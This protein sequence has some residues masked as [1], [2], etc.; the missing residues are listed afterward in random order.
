MRLALW[1]LF[2][3]GI[4][5]VIVSITLY[6]AI[7]TWLENQV[8]NNLSLTATQV[9]SVLYDA[10]EPPDFL[11]LTDVNVQ[12]ANNDSIA[13]QSFLRDQLFFVRL[14]SVSDANIIGTSV[15]YTIPVEQQSLKYEH[16]DTVTT[17]YDEQIHE[18]RLYTMSLSYNPN[19][20]LQVGVSLKDTREIQY[21]I[22]RILLILLLFTATVATLSGWFLANRA[23]VPIRAIASTA[24][25]INETD[26]SQRLDMANS[27]VE[28]EQLVEIFNAM[29]ERIE[30]AFQRQR[31]LTADAAHE[32]RTPLSVMRTSLDVILSQPRSIPEYQTSLLSV[33]EEVERMSQLANT[34]LMLARSDAHELTVEKQAVDLSLMLDTITEQFRTKANDKKIVLVKKIASEL[35]IVGDEDRLIQVVYNLMDNAVKYTSEG[36]EVAI[37]ARAS[38]VPNAVAIEIRDTGCGISQTDLPH[39]FNRFYRVDPARTREQGGFGLGLAI[40]KHIVGLHHGHIEVQSVLGQ[41]TSFT[42]LLPI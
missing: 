16:F 8:N 39:I 41:G 15:D 4:T 5:Q 20:A 27:E 21:D 31:Q 17:H 34:L 28:L 26:L 22:V 37:I 2:L 12:L 40:V 7:S 19:F 10:E 42:L 1:G 24:T 36:G 6:V 23:L 3:F 25:K 38:K 11:D 18:I 29:L 35:D 14:V 9:S 30:Q 13:T 32:L 33:Q